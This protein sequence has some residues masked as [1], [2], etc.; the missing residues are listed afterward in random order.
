MDAFTHQLAQRRIDFP[1]PLDPVQPG[2]D[3][4]FNDQCEMAFAARVMASMANMLVAL[5]LQDQ[6]GG[7]K[8]GRQP[9]DHFP[10][11]RSGGGLGHDSYIEGLTYED[12]MEIRI[13]KGQGADRIEG[14]RQDGSSFVTALPHKGPVPHDLVHF[15][16]EQEL[17]FGRGFWGLVA[18]GRH[19]EEITEMA[20][21]AGH[22]SAKR[23]QQPDP[24]FVQAIQVERIVEAFEAEFWSH[25]QDN[26]GLR[27]M[28]EAGCSQSLV[29]FPIVTDEAIDRARALLTSFARKWAELSVGETLSL[30]WFDKGQAAA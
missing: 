11:D 22:A 24:H 20:K 9:F 25:G 26:D 8:G 14:T 27:F 10:G 1:L 30:Q 23:S 4:T 29:P 6:A 15:V 12:A 18:E 16:V 13:I 28:A 19:P 3:G 21:A 7:G 17:G 2:E 5:V